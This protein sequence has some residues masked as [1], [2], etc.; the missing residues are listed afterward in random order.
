MKYVC[1]NNIIIQNL[2][3]HINRKPICD[4]IYQILSS[5]FLNS[6][7]RIEILLK[8]FSLFESSEEII[9][10]VSGLFEDILI[11]NFLF[12]F[13]L[14]NFIIFEKI[15]SLLIKIPSNSIAYQELLRVLIKFYEL[16]TNKNS[17]F[18]TFQFNKSIF[19]TLEIPL[20]LIKNNFMNEFTKVSE[21]TFSIHMK[22]L[23]LRR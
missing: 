11:N 15:H 9:F 6:L 4:I 19:E 14:E 13:I 23:G 7:I 8:F 21:S 1:N 5:N 17:K 18:R 3:K 12:D 22:V 2:L 10:C 20:D 16:F